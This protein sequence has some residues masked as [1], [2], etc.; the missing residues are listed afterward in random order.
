MALQLGRRGKM[1]CVVGRGFF[2]AEKCWGVTE[3]RAS[4]IKFS[5]LYKERVEW[6]RLI[7]EL[8]FLLYQFLGSERRFGGAV[9]RHVH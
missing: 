1:E 6:G 8:A 3:V 2:N 9:E 7:L 5:G 4:I